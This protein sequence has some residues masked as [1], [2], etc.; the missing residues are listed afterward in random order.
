LTLRDLRLQWTKSLRNVVERAKELEIVEK[1][2]C[3]NL[4]TKRHWIRIC[5]FWMSKKHS[6]LRYNLLMVK[7]LWTL[8]RRQCSYCLMNIETWIMLLSKFMLC[9]DNNTVSWFMRINL[10]LKIQ[11]H[12]M[13]QRNLLWRVINM[14]NFIVVLS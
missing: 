10:I 5:L 9:L 4:M 14:A 6:F 2:N 12:H 11:Q 13:L 3:C 8:L 7:M 1:K